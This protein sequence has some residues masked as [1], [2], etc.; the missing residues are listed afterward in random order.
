[1]VE[2]SL[3]INAVICHY[4]PNDENDPYFSINS[5]SK[6]LSD[7]YFSEPFNLEMKLNVESAGITGQYNKKII[8]LAV[9][10][11]SPYNEIVRYSKLLS[12]SSDL[13]LMKFLRSAWDF[14]FL[15]PLILNLT[16]S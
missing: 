16:F 2:V 7:F 12:L 1:M 10:A 4:N 9:A 15:L 6:E 3:S 5:V 8:F 14:S 13:P 11:K